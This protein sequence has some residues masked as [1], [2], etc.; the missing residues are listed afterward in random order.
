[1]VG[2]QGLGEVGTLSLSSSQVMA[3]V[4][5]EVPQGGLRGDRDEELLCRLHHLVGPGGGGADWVLVSLRGE[6]A[7]EVDT[8]TENTWVKPV[9]V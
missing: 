3:E 2:C 9:R 5:D 8:G 4:D 7:H 1:M 6:M